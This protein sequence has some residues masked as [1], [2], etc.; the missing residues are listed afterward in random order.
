MEKRFQLFVRRHAD[1]AVTASV[2][3]HPHLASFAQDVV[4]A[5]ADLEAVL[6]KILARDLDGLA[7]A[8]TW[9]PRVEVRRVEMVLRARQHR[10]L[11]PV[12]MRFTVLVRPERARDGRERKKDEALSGPVVIYIPRL[13]IERPLDAIE[14]LDAY[15]DEL[16][17][18]E[19][20]MAPFTRLREVAYE[21]AESVESLLVRYKPLERKAIRAHAE[22]ESSRDR[23]RPEPLPPGL[24]EAAR[25]LNDEAAAG[26]IDRAFQRDVELA[27]LVELLT[28]SRRASVLLVGATAVGKS[29]LVNELAHRAA[30]AEPPS[31]LAGLEV[32]TTSGAR[33]VAGMRY[34]GEWQARLQRMLASLRARRAV[35]HVESLSEFLATFGCLGDLDGAA[36][37]LPA[38][39]SGELTL[40]VET[41]PEDLARAERTHASFVQALRAVVL[42][43]LD[44]AGAWLA[45][46]SAAQRVARVRGVRFDPSAL[47]A[48]AELSERFGAAPLPGAAIALLRA[49]ATE[50]A[51]PDRRG[52][53]AV[54]APGVIAA[55][56]RQTG[57]PQELV[58]A[59][60]PMDPDAVFARLRQRVVGQDD[61]L[62][63]LRDLVVTLKTAMGDPRKPLGSF[64]LLGPTGVG[65]TESALALAEYLFG[66]AKRLVRFDM[67]EYADPG[68]AARLVGLY[69]SDGALA[70]KV[71]EQPF[72]VLLFDEVEKADGGVHDLLLQ[73]LG[74]G[75]ITD[76]TGRTVDLRNAIVVM[77]SN[78]GA[79]TA[80][81]APGFVDARDTG[82][83]EAHYRAAAAAF[84][85]PELLNRIDHVVPYRPLDAVTVRTI[86]RRALD[87]A[88]AREGIT[89]RGVTVRYDDAVVDALAAMGID[90]RYGARPLKRTIERRVVAPISALLAIRGA[91]APTSIALTAMGDEVVV[92]P[93]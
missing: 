28:L 11:L 53:R 70:R 3:G 26:M 74:E 8:T 79:D 22:D 81:R 73:V 38:V 35:L 19:L 1:G 24:A 18:H 63:L 9:W 52:A 25:R 14:D 37:L 44:R 13:G 62:A 76:A 41:T 23:R 31:P 86:T 50:A 90:P 64:L 77:T 92:T 12:P 51:T 15:V 21:G 39:E 85:R 83:Q 48:A 7:H 45:L 72:G 36:Y 82:S 58:D 30:L 68:S 67:S 54:G 65:K 78:L 42:R 43:P 56:S 32:Y 46:T 84:F 34:L 60:V 33:I 55:F 91:D 47:R 59:S 69:G 66:D 2:L 87:E 4:D 57:Y 75:R 89:R 71:R 29:A 93:T 16:I 5:R 17:R 27:Q 6:E 61:A 40:L 80:R 88:L 49:A 10:R 20:F